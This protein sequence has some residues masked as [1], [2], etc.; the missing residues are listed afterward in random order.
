[1]AKAKTVFFCKECG[2]ESSG[3]LGK[4]P[5]CGSWNTFVE[6]KLTKETDGKDKVRGSFAK[7]P[8]CPFPRSRAE[9]RNGFLH[10]TNS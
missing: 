2:Y 6:E 8:L 1:M 3:W 9:A 5:G 7:A 4:C 10:S